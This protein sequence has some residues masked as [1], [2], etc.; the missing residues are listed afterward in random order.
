M[1]QDGLVPRAAADGS[2]ANQNVLHSLDDVFEA[3]SDAPDHHGESHPSDMTRLQTEHTTA[4]Y[5]EGIAQGKAA[6]IQEG[7]DQ[8]FSLGAAIGLRAGQLL[9]ILQGIVEAVQSL[10]DQDALQARTL[11]AEAR[12]QLR[13]EAIYDAAYWE[14]DGQWKYQVQGE[15][16]AEPLFSDVADAHPLIQKWK[17]AVDSQAR[18]WG[19]NEAIFDDQ[20]SSQDDTDAQGPILDTGTQEAT[21]APAPAAAKAALDW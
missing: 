15:A 20:E 16:G 14:P 1:A 10:E 2:E 6:T 21:V 4:G 17:R 9:G 13:Q 11:L 5:R 8:G 12:H 18:R 19:L 3:G 7:F